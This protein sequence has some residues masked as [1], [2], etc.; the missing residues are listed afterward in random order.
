MSDFD[1]VK[2]ASKHLQK[3]IQDMYNE[4]L[5][6]SHAHSAISGA[7]GYNSKIALLADNGNRSI[8]DEFVL[9]HEGGDIDEAGLDDAIERMKDSPLK[10]LPKYAVRRAVHEALI[11]EC[12]CCGKKTRHSQPLFNSDHP[13]EPIAQVCGSCRHDE[14]EYDTCRYCGSGILYRASEINSAG[15]CREHRGESAL[16]EEEQDDWDS[17]IENITKD[18]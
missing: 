16:S 5:G 4:K 3:T 6:S 11:P 13:D 1:I 15:E 17:Y 18:L 7:L 12:E 2:K 14:D 10:T 8:D 9:F